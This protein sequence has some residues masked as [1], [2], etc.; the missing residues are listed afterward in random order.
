MLLTLPH[1]LPGNLRKKY[2]L[3]QVI[4]YSLFILIT[5][6]I[7]YGFLFPYEEK[8]FT[9]GKNQS[10]KNT[11]VLPMNS[12]FE[13]AENGQISAHNTLSLLGGSWNT[14]E[15]ADITVTPS[16]KSLGSF[17]GLT[18][19]VQRGAGAFFFPKET[20]SL[21]F[22]QK[23]LFLFE[24]TFYE[25]EASILKPFVSKSAFESY[26]PEELTETLSA[27]EFSQK[28]ISPDFIGFR[29]GTLLAYADGVFIVGKDSEFSAFASPEVLLRLGYTFDHVRQ[30]SAEETGIYKKTGI[31]L[32]GALH[33]E[34][35]LFFDE[36]SE[37]AFL[38]QGSHLW[39]LAPEY[40]AFLRKNN[41][42]VSLSSAKQNVSTSCLLTKNLF[43]NKYSCT[44]PLS[45]LT[46]DGDSYRIT[47]VNDTVSILDTESI[48]VGFQSS[49]QKENAMRILGNIRNNL[50]ERFG[51][52]YE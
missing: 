24:D 35:T 16:K 42:L 49:R 36:D 45:L 2:R 43:G 23:K 51:I 1:Y 12:S 9:F 46:A 37:T 31:L 3:L 21:N 34:G 11:L 20:M 6:L 18:V 44:V 26:Y 19:S 41:D 27:E 30:V 50:L 48:T 14:L 33:P 32:P 39:P 13:S 22:P 15:R 10:S 52:T 8:N 4:L 29:P 25:E 47:L 5:L 38:L 28:T 7:V 40:E 17:Q